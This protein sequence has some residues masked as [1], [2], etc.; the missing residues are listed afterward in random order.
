MLMLELEGFTYLSTKDGLL[1]NQTVGLF[2]G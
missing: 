1:Q 2:G